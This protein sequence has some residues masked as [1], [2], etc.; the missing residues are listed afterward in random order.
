MALVVGRALDLKFFDSSLSQTQLKTQIRFKL[1]PCGYTSAHSIEC[2]SLYHQQI[3][4]ITHVSCSSVSEA[5][6]GLE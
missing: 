6:D 5:G 3:P 4:A 1:T 2:F